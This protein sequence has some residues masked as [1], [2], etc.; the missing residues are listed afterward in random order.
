VIVGTC[1]GGTIA[2]EIAFRLRTSGDSAILILLESWHPSSAPRALFSGASMSPL[3]SIFNNLMG[4]DNLSPVARATWYAIS[5]YDPKPLPGSLLH[6]IAEKRALRPGTFDSRHMWEQRVL[7]GSTTLFNPAI[8]SGQMFVTPN[9]EPLA[10]ELEHYI[11]RQL[12]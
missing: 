11:A 9:V 7:D 5:R 10:V 2:Y 4:R 6:I 8:D 12:G 1:T 3:E